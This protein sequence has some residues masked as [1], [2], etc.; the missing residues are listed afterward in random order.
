MGRSRGPETGEERGGRPDRGLGEADGG[1]HR[2]GGMCRGGWLGPDS[3]RT[4]KDSAMERQG[5]PRRQ[6][7]RQRLPSG[8]FPSQ[9]PRVVLSWEPAQ[10]NAPLPQPASQSACL[11]ARCLPPA[12][13][14]EQAR[15][16]PLPRLPPFSLSLT[17]FGSACAK[18]IWNCLNP[19]IQPPPPLQP[20]S[21]T[22]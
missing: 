21:S 12:S 20:D 9:L 2:A 5:G 22:V 7:Q 6:R 17:S 11:S 16:P 14:P 15:L 19:N 18:P 1:R 3:R 13:P 8:L 4:T 10:L